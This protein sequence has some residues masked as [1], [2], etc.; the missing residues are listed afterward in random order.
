M[1]EIPEEL[2]DEFYDQAKEAAMSLDL[3]ED[4]AEVAVEDYMDSEFL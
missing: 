4:E 1:E 2:R 3:T